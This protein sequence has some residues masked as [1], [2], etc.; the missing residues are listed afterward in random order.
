MTTSLIPIKGIGTATET[1][2]AAEGIPD[3]P[4]LLEKAGTAEERAALAAKLKTNEKLVYSW[5]KQAEL[6]RVNG[7]TPD[8]ADLLVRIGVRDVEDLARLNTEIALPLIKSCS[9]SSSPAIKD[10]PTKERLVDI[11][12]RAVLMRPAISRD[13]GEPASIVVLSAPEERSAG[14]SAAPAIRPAG[15]DY[16]YDMGDVI[17]SVG[18]G[19]AEAQHALDMNAIVTQQQI[20]NDDDLRTWGIS[21]QW[22]TIPEATVNL[23]MSYQL[24]REHVEEGTIGTDTG[25]KMRLMVSPINAKYTNTFKVSE[26]LQSELNLKF[27]PIPAPTRWTEQIT[28]PDFTGMTLA[29]T[30]ERIAA[31]GMKLGDVRLAEGVS[32]RDG[33]VAYQSPPAG[34]LVWLAEKLDVRLAAL[35]PE[36]EPESEPKSDAEGGEE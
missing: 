14:E 33:V 34:I 28:V 8:T 12:S 11:K 21:A 19:I 15:D 16:F 4:A 32:E 2:L 24:T 23:K 1:K 31:V 30:K 35:V 36:P 6:L 17:S 25:R 3:I 7:M 22:Y 20:N 26:T 13:P 27:L 9:D 29:E 5:V 10:F 18:R